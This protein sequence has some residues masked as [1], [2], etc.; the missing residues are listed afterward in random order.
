MI[1]CSILLG[2]TFFDV[3]ELLELKKNDKVFFLSFIRDLFVIGI[4]VCVCVRPPTG[5][6]VS[7]N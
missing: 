4:C 5:V 1:E 3:L 7:F 2:D 6:C